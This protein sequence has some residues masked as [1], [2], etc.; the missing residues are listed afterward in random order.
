MTRTVS[1][2]ALPTVFDGPSGLAARRKRRPLLW[3]RRLA[4][5][6]LV[7][8]TLL[9]ALVF[10]GHRL[11]TGTPEAPNIEVS[12]SKQRE[13]SR[14]FEQRQKR[15]PN[16]TERKQLVERYVEDE[17]LFR[18]GL[19]LSLP[20]T[21]PLLRG[22][23]IARVRGLLQSELEQKPPTEAELQRY[24]QEHLSDYAIPETISYQEYWIHRDPAAGS[25]A[26]QLMAALRAEKE[27]D[28]D[29]P[30][31]ADYSGRALAQLI[32]LYD[33]EVARSLWSLPND[34][35]HELR[36]ERGIH[37]VRIKGHEPASQPPFAEVRERVRASYLKSQAASALQAQLTQLTSRWRVA[38]ATEGP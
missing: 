19:R 23:I 3:A 1:P 35:W 33:E 13:L 30:A 12:A 27:P 6:P 21:D 29:L 7:H 4:S 22:Q 25:Q 37:I 34:S 11:L 31:K 28:Q 24:Y 38:V 18:E 36:S 10:A 2:T 5:E 16:E 17:A 26:R 15:A 32:S 8:F 20:Q 14:L 9:G